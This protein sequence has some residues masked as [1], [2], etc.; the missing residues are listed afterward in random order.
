[1]NV[2]LVAYRNATTGAASKSTY[3]LDLQEAPNVSL[4]FQF[5]EIKN[6]ETRKGS[7]SQTF[8]LPFTDNNNEFFQNWF[9]VNLETLV[10]S[11]KKKFNAVLYIGTIPQFEG[12]IQLKSVYQK[13]QV[14]EVVL[15][16]NTADLFSVIG[17]KKLRDVFKN[18]D[19]SM[20]TELNHTFNATNLVNS[21]N[22]ATTS[23]QNTAGTSLRD[24]T[25]GVQKV[26]YPMSVTVPKFWFQ[27][28][29]GL[30]LDMNQTNVDAFSSAEDAYPFL[31]PIT[32]FRPAVQLKTLLQ[33]II[34]RAGF[35]YTSN[36]IDGAYFGKLF[37]TT[38]GHTAGASGVEI[39]TS[40]SVN[41]T[42]SVGNSS[43]FGSYSF[44]AGVGQL[45]CYQQNDFIQVVAD[46]TTVV[47]GYTVPSDINSL[48]NTS[49][50]KF[51][52]ET[53]NMTDM[54]VKFVIKRE[55][56]HAIN[57]YISPTIADCMEPNTS[58]YKLFWELRDGYGDEDNVY[59]WGEYQVE[60]NYPFPQSAGTTG[61]NGY[62]FVE[63][64]I[65]LTN[66][67]VGNTCTV[68]VKAEKFAKNVGSSAATMTFGALPCQTNSADPAYSCSASDYFFAGLFNQITV[69]WQGYESNIYGQTVDVP[70]GI[71]EKITQKGFLKDIIERFNLV[72][73]ADPN[74]ATNI[75]IEPYND[76]IASG[77]LKYWTNK[78][79]LDKE[80]VV[81]D[82][83]TMQNEK[84]LLTDLEDVDLANKSIKDEFPDYNVYGK[85]DIVE[86]NNQFAS[87]EMKNTPL[88]SPYINEKVFAGNVED[89]PTQLPNMAVQYE[90]TYKAVTGGYEDVL[91]ATQSKLFYYCGTP[92][93]INGTDNIHFHSI[94]LSTGVI[95]A[96]D[97]TTYPLCSP[98]D[99]TP[100][101]STGQS[102]LTPTTK[103]LYW[104]QNPPICGQL[105]VFNYQ[106]ESTLLSNSLYYQY[107][108]QYF[109][110]IY[111]EDSRIMEC[112]LNL[113]EVDIFN[114]S[115]AD[116]IFIKDSY[117][118]I[119]NISNYQVGTKASTK[120]TLIKV[121]EVYSDTCNGCDFVVGE[122]SN[123][124]NTAGPLF[125]WCASTTPDCTPNLTSAGSY[126]GLMTSPECCDCEN[127]TF[128]EI[129]WSTA[130]TGT[131]ICIANS[132]S[133]PIQIA[134]LYNSRFLFSNSNTKSLYSGK[135]DGLNKPIITGSNNTKY[136][137]PILPYSGND[138]V[139][140][141]NTN[142]K[143]IPQLAGES[144][145]IV[146]SGYTEG[147]T[148]GY[149]Y[150][151][152]DS[153]Q[154]RI[155]IPNYCNMI[156]RVKGTATVIGGKSAT[157]TLGTTEGFAYYTAFKSVN[158]HIE[159][160]STP[161]GQEEFSI[162][163][164]A[165]PT[166]CTLNIVNSTNELQFGLDDSQTDTKRIWQLTIDIDVNNILNL[167]E[168]FGVD[169][170]RYQDFEFILL[171]NG[172]KLIWN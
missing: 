91:E 100:N 131:G 60:I 95:T 93:T 88:Y 3:Q 157:Y 79:D 50:N 44:T 169:Y 137:T 84:I 110:Q 120:V 37:M 87:G 149:A 46:T 70:Q 6:P 65:P 82:T 34:A 115:F 23:F 61:G 127:G 81:K 14:Y 78:L 139:I 113:N 73:I 42:M 150:S 121:E 31:V 104:N 59:A 132:G 40:G 106:A 146:L 142:V 143:T 52:R 153:N 67:N 29:T 138:M 133:L 21:W 148:R 66:V 30:Y 145:R 94:N 62:D 85:V 83:T 76:F 89:Y 20:S 97:I 101:A 151:Q 4:N 171:Q 68:W 125:V 160:L 72:V 124:N 86:T 136:S 12:I 33:L 102:D 74:N 168:G 156:I 53:A 90:Y 107:W 58:Y 13:A 167:E 162:R 99:L 71:D 170:A 39:P 27:S 17:S 111:N 16:S 108:S 126:A 32:Q 63:L 69:N 135:L 54:Q 129:P 96:H 117:W 166:T 45:T 140:K 41:G 112:Y 57:Q 109:N 165:N 28:G 130:G 172:D 114:F 22:G 77:E 11:T 7:Y 25:A 164:G 35:S 119:L 48:W 122:T 123:G 2:R 38:C 64:E 56:I 159:Q 80:I 144:H 26:M 147:N 158:G 154:P 103:S 75:I 116:E 98:F 1:M 163:E 47:S 134:N 19:G 49:A 10:F 9:N 161:G 118:R 5:S 152:G 141:Y 36:F 8:K 24:S 105:T 43:S 92:T 55:N 128:V 51:T 155:L 18:D 15:M